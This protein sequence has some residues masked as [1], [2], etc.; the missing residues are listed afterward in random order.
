MRTT[1]LTAMALAWVGFL[2]GT[3]ADEAPFSTF[4]DSESIGA[5]AFR[6]A[7]PEWDGRGVVIAVLD[8][9]VD[10]G[11]SGLQ[12]TTAGEVKVIEARDFTGEASIECEEAAAEGEGE[13]VLYRTRSGFVRDESGPAAVLR[14][15]VFLGFL[16]ETRFRNAAVQDLN[17]N[18]R[19]D[20]RFAVALFRDASK[21]WV[22]VVDRD[23]DGDVSAEDV[24]HSYSKDPRPL[25]LSGHDPT[26][27]LAPVSMALTIEASDQG[28]KRVEFHIPTG[29]HGTHVAGIAAGYGL[30]G[31]EGRDGIAPGARVMSL[32]IGD[33][34]LS[35][36]A[37]V[38]ESMKRALE[39]AGRWAREHRTPVVVNMSYGVGSELEGEADIEKFVNRF[40]EENPEVVMVFSAGNGGPGLSSVGSPAAAMHAI[41]VGGVV[42]PES[43]RDLI[44]ARARTTQVF[45]FSS[46]GGE[47]AKPDVCAPGIASSSVPNWEKADLFRGTSMAAPQVAGAVALLVSALRGPGGAAGRAAWNSG[48]VKR[49]LVATARPV[50]GYGPLD[51]GGGL[52]DVPAAYHRLVEM[53]RDPQARWILGYEVRV[54]SPTAP[55]PGGSAAFFRAGGWVPDETHPVTV[56]VKTRFTSDAPQ[57]VKTGWYRSFRLSSD[58]DFVGLSR[59]NLYVRGEAEAT[60]DLRVDPRAV[61]APGVHVALVRARS[62]LDEVRIPVTVVTPQRP[63]VRDG[64]PTVRLAL[65]LGP[66]EVVRIPFRAPA[67]AETLQ[68]TIEPA[69]DRPAALYVFLFDGRG[70]RVA[71]PQPVVSSEDG[72]RTEFSLSRGDGLGPDTYE[73]V[74][75]GVPTSRFES[76]VD[77]TLR[78]H[79]LRARPLR[80]LRFEPGKAPTAVTEAVQEG[81]IPFIGT[82]RGAVTGY[83]K[84]VR[85][86]VGGDV[87][88]EGVHLTREL[89]GVEFELAMSPEDYARFTDIAVAILDEQGKAVVKSGFGARVLRLRLDNPDPRRP[90]A[91]YRLEV[92][93]GRAFAGGP[94]FDLEIK[95]TYL[96]REPVPLTGTLDGQE[97][98]A[99]YPGV[100]SRIEFRAVASLPAIPADAVWHGSVEFVADRDRQ[101][102]LRLPIEA[103]PR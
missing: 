67:G 97:R 71:V 55:R 11:V 33:N 7:H 10:M 34:R 18:G 24:V 68:A 13:K 56:R 77:V 48:M 40:A 31:V 65:S 39:F 99:L 27:G 95:T 2:G 101:V 25:R 72:R 1:R 76:A 86:S 79:A 16:E 92:R 6:K 73:M 59:A 22:A 57:A 51:V 23:G 88:T 58:A 50:A 90:D 74:L 66:G 38:T 41:S 12:T 60:F 93:G 44:G 64:V 5:A 28:P 20:D 103:S 54:P 42:A 75:Y 81:D 52:V 21:E 8:T 14:P 29:S 83:R 80:S 85:K 89:R 69:R 15:P 45:H 53:A 36:G 4:L 78:F 37:T 49:A 100:L 30:N 96:W 61:S 87:L 32:K 102:W 91:S 26:R 98:L 9:G 94:S 82:A 35:G 62:G 47:L 63:V 19:D 84:V 17:G 46:R 43:A 3:R 70:H